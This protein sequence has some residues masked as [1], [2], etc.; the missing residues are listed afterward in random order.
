ML[1]IIDIGEDRYEVLR[2]ITDCNLDTVNLIL[3]HYR[4][5]YPDCHLLKL[6]PN[7]ETNVSHHLI[8]RKIDTAEV[9]NE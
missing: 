9:A 6:I 3:S 2:K 8:C 1:E 5:V 4:V 7:P